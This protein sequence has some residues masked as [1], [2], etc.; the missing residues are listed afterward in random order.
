[1]KKV[2]VN[3]ANRGSSYARQIVAG[4]SILKREKILN[5]EIYEKPELRMKTNHTIEILTDHKRII[6]DLSDGYNN[7]A[8]FAEMDEMLE[9]IDILFKACSKKDYNSQLK[10]KKKIHVLPPRYAAT[11]PGSWNEQ[12][13]FRENSVAE[14]IKSLLWRIPGTKHAISDYYYDRFECEPKII[15]HEPKVF[16]YTR[17]W[18]PKIASTKS[19]QNVDIDGCTAES[20]IESKKQEYAELSAMRAGLVRACKKEF[21]NRFIG[22]IAPDDYSRKVYPDLLGPD[23]SQRRTY[24]SIMHTAEI[25]INTWGTHKCFNFSFGEEIAASKA[26]I[27]QKPFYDIP[28]H[29]QEGRNFIC[30][31]TI[32]ECLD[33]VTGIMEDSSA[34]ESMMHSNREYYLEYLRPD[35]YVLGILRT[36][37][38]L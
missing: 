36:S 16:F 17:L 10:N 6:C 34:I 18:N 13:Q 3:V 7:Y 38:V 4:F 26:I 25:C 1:M 12:I 28:E 5:V 21:G 19:S 35:K 30:Y 24:T 32:D 20:R 31:E 22:G 8:S 27:T 37:N 33:R 14:I 29:L 11:V 15:N 23:L 9:D 2:I